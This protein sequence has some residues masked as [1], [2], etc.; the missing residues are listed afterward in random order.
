MSFIL[1]SMG[2]VCALGHHPASILKNALNGISEGMKPISG[3]LAQ[4]S[5]FFG[6]VTAALPSAPMRSQSLLLFVLAQMKADL[7]RLLAS[8][9]PHRI[10]IVLGSSNTGIHEAQQHLNQWFETEQKPADFSLEMIELGTPAV[11]L[12]KHLGLSGPAFVVST[13]CSSGAKVFASARALI[14]GGVC[15]AVLVGGVDSLCGFAMNGFHAL[16]ALSLPPTNPMSQN[17]TGINLGEGAALFIMEKGQKGIAVLGVGESS[18]AYHLTA[19]DPTGKGA[20]KAMA[21]ALKEANLP[22][23][24]I[25]YINLHG[26]GTQANDAMES[27]A[28]YALFQDKVPCA[29]TKPLTGHALGA[30]GAIEAGLCWLMLSEQ[31]QAKGY[32]PHLFDGVLDETL[33]PLWFA[34][35]G[36][37]GRLCHILSNSFAFGGSNASLILGVQS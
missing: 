5:C 29:S 11:F 27:Q 2:M 1:T 33:A 8:Y 13:A 36:Q 19:P 28:V 7:D 26:T 32:I 37:S 16:E 18:D 34:Q 6:H 17:R 15:D 25:D 12:K 22:P 24:E 31:N 23:S 14:A 3:V 10:G 20:Q 4:G 35:K 9:P 21:L 30:S